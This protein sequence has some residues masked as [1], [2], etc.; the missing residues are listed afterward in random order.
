MI[1]V[2]YP[3]M[4]LNSHN[5]P[6]VEYK[7]WNTWKVAESTTVDQMVEW[8]AKVARGA[9]SGRLSTLIFNSHGKPGCI[10]IGQKITLEH[11]EKFK[12]FKQEKLVDRVWIVAC[13]VA[14]IKSAGQITDG[15]YFCYRLA[16][17]SGAFV[18]AGSASQMGHLI[19]DIPYG[20]IDDWEGTVY[21]WDP[22]GKLIAVDHEE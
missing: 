16:Q 18:R 3:H 12:I 17:E 7:M 5:V 10:R 2:P 19:V 8:V 14:R 20:H 9:P 15:N 1:G 11:V 22:D 13:S 6:G 4:V 21:T